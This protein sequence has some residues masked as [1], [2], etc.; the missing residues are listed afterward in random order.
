MTWMENCILAKKKLDHVTIEQTKLFAISYFLI[1]YNFSFLFFS[2]CFIFL[3]NLFTNLYLAPPQGG[4][5][6]LCISP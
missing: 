5:E 3:L 4:A 2:Y 1:Q 6:N